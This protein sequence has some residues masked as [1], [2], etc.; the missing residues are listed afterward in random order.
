MQG[1][2]HLQVY[3]TIISSQHVL[4]LPFD[5]IRRISHH[6][7]TNV[8]SA[9]TTSLHYAAVT[10]RSII[11]TGNGYDWIEPGSDLPE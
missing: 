10:N 1:Q 3:H 4:S 2:I 9:T 7:D 11:N 8:V 5:Q 6:H